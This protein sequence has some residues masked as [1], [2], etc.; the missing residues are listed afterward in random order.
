[1]YVFQGTPEERGLVAW[2]AQHGDESNNESLSK[3]YDIPII[4]PILKR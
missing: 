2:K 4:T 1:M 3:T